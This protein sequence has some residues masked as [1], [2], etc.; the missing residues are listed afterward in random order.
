M[1]LPSDW[2]LVRHPGLYIVGP[3]TD[4]VVPNLTAG[5]RYNVPT[6]VPALSKVMSE[7]WRNQYAT[8]FYTR[9]IQVGGFEG[10]GFWQLPGTC[11]TVY[12]PAYDQVHDIS[13]Y[14]PLCEPDGQRLNAIGQQ[15]LES[16]QF[17]PTKLPD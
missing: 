8:N 15:I 11:L 5:F 1:R 3:A 16:L 12:V 10:V 4:P 13:W 9:T 17:Y 14:P 2:K 7:I 6:E